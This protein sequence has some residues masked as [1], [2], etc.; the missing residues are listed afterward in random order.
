MHLKCVALRS[1]KVLSVEIATSAERRECVSTPK[2]NGDL[3]VL[4][5]LPRSIPTLGARKRED[6]EE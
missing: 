1:A 2:V 5:M 3:E 4:W 6:E